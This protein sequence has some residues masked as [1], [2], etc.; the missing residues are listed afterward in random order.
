[1]SISCLDYYSSL[2]AG[3]CFHFLPMNYPLQTSQSHLF[4]YISDHVIP[5]LRTPHYLSVS[6]RIKSGLLTCPTQ[7]CMSWGLLFA[8]ASLLL[9]PSQCTPVPL[10]SVTVYD[11]PEFSTT[12]P[13]H[14][15]LPLSRIPFP[16]HLELSSN[17]TSSE[18]LGNTRRVGVGDG[19]G[20]R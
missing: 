16:C 1:M 6:L 18:D 5:M 12:G 20:G 7:H 10:A 19:H 9:F 11:P 3:L 4:L 13:L 2:P 8:L 17:A 14:L 15:L